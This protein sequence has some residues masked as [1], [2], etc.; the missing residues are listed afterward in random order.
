VAL[1]QDEGEPY[2]YIYNPDGDSGLPY[3]AGLR[4]SF[5][6]ESHLNTTPASPVHTAA[7]L[8]VG[9]G[10]SV[11][12]GL[13]LGYGLTLEGEALFRHMPLSGLTVNGTATP[14]SGYSSVAAPFL[15]LLWDVPVPD[16]PFRPFIG[17]GIGAAF[18]QTEIHNPANT[19]DYLYKDNWNFA[20]ALMGGAELPLSQSARL[21]ALYRWMRVNNAGFACGTG[22]A[23]QSCFSDI[24]NQ[25]VDLG[26]EMDL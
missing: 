2:G 20:Y 24:T 6:F 26:L 15:N 3:V 17:A 10:G 19:F 23:A 14:A 1:A 9:Y 12:A 5:A 7:A 22:G 18:T 13:R 21:T 16:F 11:Y 25:G 4:G 8:D